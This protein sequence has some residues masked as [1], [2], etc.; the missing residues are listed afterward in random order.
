MTRHTSRPPL[1][2]T[3]S[4]TGHSSFRHN[5]EVGVGTAQV[6]AA[7]PGVRV[8]STVEVG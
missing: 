2:W 6:D 3:G 8:E 1:A 4:R 5:D 7:A